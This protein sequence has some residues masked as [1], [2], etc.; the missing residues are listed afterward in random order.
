MEYGNLPA[1][2]FGASKTVKGS[3]IKRHDDGNMARPLPEYTAVLVNMQHGCKNGDSRYQVST[4]L[5]FTGCSH[6]EILKLAAE[7]AIITWRRKVNFLNA[8]SIDTL[9]NCRVDVKTDLIYSTR[10]RITNVEKVSRL[11]VGSSDA[12][13]REMIKA[14]QASMTDE[15]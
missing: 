8:A 4:E 9:N 10:E 1:R 7:S 13:K 6:D 3:T 11:A 12:E 15:S 14:M 5:N 2:L